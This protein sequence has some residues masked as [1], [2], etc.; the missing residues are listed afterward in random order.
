MRCRTCKQ[1][2]GQENQKGKKEEEV[3]AKKEEGICAEEFEEKP[4]EENGFS[5]RHFS[6]AFIPSLTGVTERRNTVA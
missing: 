4:R 5:N 3:T 1:L 2:G 6:P